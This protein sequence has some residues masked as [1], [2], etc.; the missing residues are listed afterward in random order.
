MLVLKSELVNLSL[1][2]PTMVASVLGLAVT[3]RTVTSAA[4]A[5]AARRRMGTT[6]LERAVPN[7]AWACGMMPGRARVTGLV[8]VSSP[9][10]P[11]TPAADETRH[12]MEAEPGTAAPAGFMVSVRG[13]A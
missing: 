12:E 8:A 1:P 10:Y 3:H 11:P 6:L 2:S 13:V 9:V 4:S 7:M 5:G